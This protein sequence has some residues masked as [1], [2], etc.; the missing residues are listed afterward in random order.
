[1][2]LSPQRSQ[3]HNMLTILAICRFSEPIAFNSILAYTYIMVQDLNGT[4]A[5]ASFYAGLLVSAYAVAEAITALFWGAISDRYGRKPVV[6]IGLCGVALSSLLFGLARH[7]WVALL[8]RFVGGALNG[9]V[10]VMQTMVA[11]M[12]MHTPQHEPRAYAVQPFVWFLGSIIGSAMGGFLAQPAK[13]YPDVFAADG[14]FG[15]F[16]YLLPN[17]VAVVAIALA[18]IQGMLFLEETN[19]RCKKGEAYAGGDAVGR[20]EDDDAVEFEH[21]ENTP[22]IRTTSHPI[23]ISESLRQGH[24]PLFVEESLPGAANQRFDLR[25]NSF[26]TIHS[27][28]VRPDFEDL[29]NA[30]RA[31]QTPLAAASGRQDDDTASAKAFNFSVVMLILTLV[32]AAFHQMA[33]GAILPIY[34]L[35]SPSTYNSSSFP[36][37]AGPGTFGAGAGAGGGLHFDFVGGM[38]YSLHDVGGFLAV[39]GFIALFC[40]G[41]IFPIFVEKVG[42]WYS[43]L[44]PTLVYPICYIIM[45]FLSLLRNNNSTTGESTPASEE[46]WLLPTGIYAS[47][48]VQN[49]LGIIATPCMLI[50]LKNATPS[51]LVLGRVN[52]LAMSAVCAARTVSSPL[53]GVVYD[54]WGSAAAWASCAAVAVLGAVQLWWVPR[55]VDRMELGGTEVHVVNALAHG[56]ASVAGDDAS[57]W[58]ESEAEEE[59]EEEEG[60]HR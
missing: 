39:N 12:I 55:A 51:P 45:P 10:S 54:S 31:N 15:R 58:D 29:Q 9:N 3:A 7:Y 56:G 53:V 43:F 6:L 38:G 47:M 5:N 28:S 11:E 25:H 52:G 35:D 49:L 22:L 60:S 26:G 17:L 44:L 32:F 23:S 42:V 34:L 59:E 4:D 14:L 30:R 27:I 33:F 21:D 57:V 13:F 16:P 2:S 1:M 41:V 40:Q 36:A 19:P 20:V 48:F 8:A 50:L 18:V 24:G 46:S 37:S